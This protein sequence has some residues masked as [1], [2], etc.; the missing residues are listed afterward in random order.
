MKLTCTYAKKYKAER[1]PT[2]GCEYCNN[3]WDLKQ[4]RI[5]R[6]SLLRLIKEADALGFYTKTHDSGHSHKELCRKVKYLINMSEDI[7]RW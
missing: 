5:Q 7:T 3:L 2:C 4:V 1:E 6:E